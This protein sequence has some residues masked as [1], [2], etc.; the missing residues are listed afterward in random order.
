MSDEGKKTRKPAKKPPVAEATDSEAVT[1]P[2]AAAPVKDAPRQPRIRDYLLAIFLLALG[3]IRKHF[4]PVL[5]A[6]AV[7]IA[8]VLGTRFWNAHHRNPVLANDDLIISISRRLNI[9]GDPNPAILTVIDKEKVDQPFLE[10]SKEGDKILLYYKSA[11]A[12]LYRPI[13]DKIIKSGSFTPPAAK[14]QIRQGTT[15]E[16]R[17]TDVTDLVRKVANTEVKTRDDSVLKDYTQT[18]VVNVTGRYDKEAE[19]V[20]KAVGGTLRTPPQNETIP[21]ADILVIVGAK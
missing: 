4:K 6:L 1:E 18:L 9:S 21:D 16:K 15:A 19:A 2:A 17:V 20:A 12:V 13:E 11:K 5:V 14:V 3:G 7:I 10:D 8:L